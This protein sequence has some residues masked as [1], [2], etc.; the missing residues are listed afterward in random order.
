MIKLR[1]S[2]YVMNNAYIHKQNET[3]LM[4]MTDEAGNKTKTKLPMH[5]IAHLHLF[6]YCTV[7]P[8]F[9][10]M[11]AENNTTISY[12]TPNGKFLAR[13][14]G[15]S[16]GNVLLRQAQYKQAEHTPLTIAQH[17]ITAKIRTSRAILQR[18]QRNH[19][20]HS[21]VT[22]VIDRMA[23]IIEAIPAQNEL[24]KLRGLEGEAASHYFGVFNHL[25][26]RQTSE[27]QLNRRTRR[28]PKDPINAMLSFLYSVL[29][30]EIAG[31]LE[32]VGLD[33][34]V[35]FL[36]RAR[37]GRHSLA[38]DLL[39]EFRGYIV[40]RTV[41]NLVNLQQVKAKDFTTDTVGGVVLKDETRKVL[42]KAYNARKL[43]EIVHPVLDE[44]IQI[45][46]LPHCQAMLLARHLRGDMQHYVPFFTR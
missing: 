46:L 9:M 20:K 23:Q 44:K 15:K 18:H 39:E 12:Y 22:K 10:Q 17:L 3:V 4:E 29:G 28:P 33:P 6:G 8:Y 36:H 37:P 1:N 42:L 25:L 24:E 32:G 43:E 2:L 13:C 34:Q 35:G 45:G 31:A 27:L 30:N 14:V 11:C 19:G 7:S 5:G 26:T 40:D 38:L 21:E 41:I 16:S